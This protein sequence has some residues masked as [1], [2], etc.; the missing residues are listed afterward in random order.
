MQSQDLR[1]GT[2]QILA[3]FEQSGRDHI[4]EAE[5]DGWTPMGMLLARLAKSDPL[6][7]SLLA[8]TEHSDLLYER[9]EY[10]AVE[11]V[12]WFEQ[13][14]VVLRNADGTLWSE[15]PEVFDVQVFLP[16]TR[17]VHGRPDWVPPDGLRS[18]TRSR[19]SA[20]KRWRRPTI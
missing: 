16:R 7:V 8:M 18:G 11:S 5:A 12:G 4:A 13:G 15:V 10:R 20:A 6:S 17:E 2:A 1:I 9:K 19:A 14:P 3:R